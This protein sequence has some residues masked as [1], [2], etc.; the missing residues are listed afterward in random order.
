METT[1]P[2]TGFAPNA[3]GADVKV[4]DDTG[5]DVK[6]H[7]DNPYLSLLFL[8]MIALTA[9]L[10]WIS[11]LTAGPEYGGRYDVPAVNGAAWFGFLA[12]IPAVF[13]VGGLW[14]ARVEKW[15]DS[16]R[17]RRRSGVS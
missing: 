8:G 14:M 6:D 5:A 13:V 1:Q 17:E 10:W 11:G 16:R 2:S 4:H 3:N 7:G 15:V 9:F 12:S